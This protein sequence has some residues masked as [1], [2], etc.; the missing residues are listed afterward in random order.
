MEDDHVNFSWDVDSPDVPPRPYFYMK[1]C[2]ALGCSK[3]RWNSFGVWS[4][5]GEHQCRMR[6]AAHLHQHPCHGWPVKKA[7][8]HAFHKSAIIL[9]HEESYKD[10]EYQRKEAEKWQSKTAEKTKEEPEDEIFTFGVQDVLQEPEEKEDSAFQSRS[11]SPP[12]RHRR[13]QRRRCWTPRR[14]RGTMALMDVNEPQYFHIHDEDTLDDL[15]EIEQAEA[16]LRHVSEH[17]QEVFNNIV[18]SAG[19]LQSDMETVR[20][21]MDSVHNSII[22]RTGLHR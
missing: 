2:V 14:R 1:Q 16:A 17:L 15:A 13:H 21:V 10:R 18:S 20:T 8:R 3:R 7:L 5:N 12:R 6:Y 22:R 9:K 4:Y 11:R 19:R